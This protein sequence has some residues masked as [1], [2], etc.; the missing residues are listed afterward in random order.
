[1]LV[2]LTTRVDLKR[3]LQLTHSASISP[4]LPECASTLTELLFDDNWFNGMIDRII[5]ISIEPSLNHRLQSWR[6]SSLWLSIEKAATTPRLS[7]YI[8]ELL[9][10]RCLNK[11]TL[12]MYAFIVSTFISR[13]IFQ[14]EISIENWWHR[15]GTRRWINYTTI[16]NARLHSVIFGTVWKTWSKIRIHINLSIISTI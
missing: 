8:A 7:Y 3:L 13:G 1:M 11:W 9:I 2:V 10:L 16:K 5:F 14:M 15:G 6:S 4:T 12:I